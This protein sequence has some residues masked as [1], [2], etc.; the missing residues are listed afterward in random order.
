MDVS[1]AKRTLLVN[2]MVSPEKE[3]QSLKSRNISHILLNLIDAY[4]FIYS[5]DPKGDHSK[6]YESLLNDFG[7]Q[8]TE[9]KKISQDILSFSINHFSIL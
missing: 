3:N 6:A 1:Q 5:L 8:E 9:I 7:P 4:Y 2:E